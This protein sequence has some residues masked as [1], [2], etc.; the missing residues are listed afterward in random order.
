MATFFKPKTAETPY[1][2][3][4]GVPNQAALRDVMERLDQYGIQFAAYSEPDFGM[5]LS[6]IATV[7]LHDE[8]RK[9]LAEY[10]TWKPLCRDSSDAE[11]PALNRKVEDSSP[12]R[13]A[14][15]GVV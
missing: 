14:Y 7:P 13:G 11:R 1:L 9:K 2:V 8:D 6:A 5:G 15:A 3:L 12:S 4:I 10:Q